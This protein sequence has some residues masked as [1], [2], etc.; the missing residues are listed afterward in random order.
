M[1]RTL[2]P[3][4]LGLMLAAAPAR[5]ADP[6]RVEFFEKQVRPVLV[7]RCL[8]C[9]GPDKQRGGLRLD[10]KAG[11]Q[12]GGDRGPAVVPGKPAES[13]LVQAVRGADGVERMPPKDRLTDRELA[14]LTKW[15]ADGAAD[16][17]D[18]AA[19]LGGTTLEA[20]R[21][22]WAF[23]PVRR[24]PVPDAGFANPVDAFVAAKL[25][26]RGLTHSP[27]ADKR[28]LLRRATYDLT[29]LPPTPAEV[30]AF[31]ADDS[32]VAF[33]RVVDRLL[34]SPAYG[35]RWGRHWLDLVRY[36]DTA[37]ENS[38]HPLPHAWRYRNWVIDAVNRD[39][40]YDEFVREQIAG[41]LLAA[42]G[43]PDKYA[44]R[45]V[46]TGFLAIARRFDHD[47]DKSMHLTHEDGIDTLGKALL[48][49][50][51]GCARCH[52]H[53][54]DAV[55]ARD[56][57]A[58]YGILDSTKFSFPG[59]EAKQQP[60][61]LVPLLP[62]AEWDRVVKP[63]Q[64]K[65]A[66]LDTDIRAAEATAAGHGR[67]VQAAFE[68]S[69][70][71]LSVG[72][73]PD[74]GDARFEVPAVEV[75]PGQ[76]VL[77]SVTPLKSHGADTTLVEWEIAE[78]GGAGRRW[79][80]TADLVGDLLAGNP[81]AD[82][83]GHQQVWW[84]FD[85]RNRPTPLPEAVR[86]VNGK[87]GLAAWRNGDTPSV[88]ANAATTEA[89]VWTKLPARSL[90]VHPSQNGNVGV[91]WL[92]PVSGKVRI[93]GRLKDAHPGGPD[94]VG[95]VVERF[96]AD[97]RAGLSA[98]ATAAER[99]R[100]LDRRR[101]D[102]ARTAPKQEV[103][104]AV[105]EGKPADARLHLRGDPEKLGDAVPRRWLEVLGGTPV[106][107]KATS[108]RLELADWVVSKDNP[109]TARVMANRV[110]LHHFG[111]GLVKTPND[112]G[113]RG[114]PPTH[115]ELLDWLAAEFVRTG[116]SVK[117]LHRTVMLSATYR[118]ASGPRADAAGAD[119][120][121]DLYWRFDRRR[122]SAEE[123]RDS[124]L[125]ASGRLDRA[126]A[127]AHPFPPESAWNYTQHV[128]FG[129]FFETDKRS[130]YLVAVR[131][132]RHPFLGLFD[133]ADPNATTPQRQ[134]TT[135]PTQALFFL[136]DPFFHAQADAVTARVL[137]KPGPERAGE[138]FRL[139]F[140][141]PPTPGER[142][143]AAAFLSRYRTALAGASQAD[144]EKAAWSALARV[145]LASNEFLF[146]E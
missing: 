25:A 107:D 87:A 110:W 28:T 111:K 97:T 56:Y 30:A 90:F 66:E 45:V 104:F 82:S 96:S 77:L 89:A 29:G 6:D 10:S 26:A 112:F 2:P 43:P 19:R 11:W 64:K 8:P 85:T 27:P 18:G 46:A 128:P 100:D 68:R 98:L 67:E 36:A 113:T 13:L 139:A 51:L 22:W 126:P 132:R 39:Q 144:G 121:N 119:P 95:W 24:P 53:K 142:E 88:L 108:G 16:P 52:D 80:A 37:G 124:L 14:A 76:M 92:S 12:A 38:D 81:H 114:T 131:N 102:L 69:R 57:Y 35:E 141:R 101:A 49:L 146:V 120:A 84:L 71:R 125:A 133:G 42:K 3:L 41:D 54:Y 91:G 83:H 94:G 73:I 74:C 138:L 78:Q 135:V 136:N 70:H 20:A 4:C 137:A 59:C 123:I 1:T 63:Y 105:T 106:S 61:D 32:P 115:P 44:A 65:L 109:L 48:G 58:L 145:L 5:A 93:T 143:F 62:P 47:S 86:D 55:T 15:V 21:G 9:H 7:Q 127:A 118:Q 34:A 33:E 129:T 72:E 31:L 117:A 40:P 140:Q 23:Q 103:A 79:N 122:L 134:A 130:V 99:R 17:R 50:T 116:W 75:A 60:R